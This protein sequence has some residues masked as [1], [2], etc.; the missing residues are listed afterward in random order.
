MSLTLCLK[1][2]LIF[3]TQLAEGNTAIALA[4]T[5]VSNM[6][7]ILI[8]PFSISKFI[9]DGVGV[10]VPTAELLRSLLLTLLLPLILGKV[11]RESFR[12]LANFVDHNRKVFL[13]ISAVFLSLV[14][15]EISFFQFYFTYNV[16]VSINFNLHCDETISLF[17]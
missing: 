13:N 14:R 15:P 8:I 3:Y 16:L 9:A 1:K 5:V 2:A 10:H 11:L 4:M 7:G 12:G 17:S 6:L